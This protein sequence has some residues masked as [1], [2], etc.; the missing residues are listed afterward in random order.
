MPLSLVDTSPVTTLGPPDT[1]PLLV[2]ITASS[3]AS[4]PPTSGH[5]RFT[6]HR[7]SHRRLSEPFSE[8]RGPLDKAPNFWL[9]VAGPARAACPQ[10]EAH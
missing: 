3:L 6:L 8:A 4:L 1:G 5:L 9:A 7:S 2:I 10:K